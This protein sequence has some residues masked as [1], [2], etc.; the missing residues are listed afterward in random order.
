[1]DV[2]DFAKSMEWTSLHD[3]LVAGDVDL[4]A[5]K[6][7]SLWSNWLVLPGVDVIDH[8]K[9]DSEEKIEALRETFSLRGRRLEGAVLIGSGL[10]K[11]DFTGARLQG[12]ELEDVDLREASIGCAEVSEGEERG[13]AQLQRVSL[14][15]AQLQ[16]AG[17]EVCPASGCIFDE[18]RLSGCA[19]K[20]GRASRR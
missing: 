2:V 16:G 19:V 9:F 3:L 8:A 15:D 10:R 13:C 1:M 5:R 6:P 14:S 17:F 11:V 4:V 7:R 18:G 12:A 20:M